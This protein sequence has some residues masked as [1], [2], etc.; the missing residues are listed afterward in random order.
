MASVD[1]GMSG[2]RVGSFNC[3]GLGNANKRE[4]VLNW[5]KSK[6]EEV[7]MLQETHT[8]SSTEHAWRREW[9]GDIIFNHGSSNSTGVTILFKRNSNIKI[10]NYRNIVQGR[11]TLVEIEVD[12]VNFCLV[13]VYCPNNNETSVVETVFLESLG[14]AR[15]EYPIIGGTGTQ[16]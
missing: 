4:L 14:R 10:C 2:L 13:N 7:I 11:V 12:S 15:D 8:T 6:P 16:Y 5:L 3:N 1:L 9:E